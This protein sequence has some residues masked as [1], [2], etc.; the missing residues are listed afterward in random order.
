MSH[1]RAAT[2]S[3]NYGGQVFN[4]QTFGLRDLLTCRTD[5]ERRDSTNGDKVPLRESITGSTFQARMLLIRRR[6]FARVENDRR[7][8]S[9]SIMSVADASHPFSILLTVFLFPDRHVYVCPVDYRKRGYATVCL[10]YPTATVAKRVREGH[11]RILSTF[12]VSHTT[13]FSLLF[14]SLSFSL[15]VCVAVFLSFLVL[16]QFS[17]THDSPMP[18]ASFIPGGRTSPTPDFDSRNFAFSRPFVSFV[19]SLAPFHPFSEPPSLS[20]LRLFTN[21]RTHFHPSVVLRSA[22]NLVRAYRE[23]TNF[24]HVFRSKWIATRQKIREAL[25]GNKGSVIGSL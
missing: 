11:A 22:W 5:R 13:S 12:L 23:K 15:S 4:T 17:T 2:H 24:S 3:V 9:R 21:Y 7:L 19:A 20:L 18:R 10:A 16:S 6:K 25:P 14:P 1:S 8:P